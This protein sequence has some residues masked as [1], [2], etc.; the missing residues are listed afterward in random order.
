MILAL[1]LPAGNSPV[2]AG[3]LIAASQA[4]TLWW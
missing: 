4:R 3:S 2:P 1:P